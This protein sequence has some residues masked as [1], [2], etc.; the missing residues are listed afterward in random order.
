[1]HESALRSRRQGP[2]ARQAGVI[3]RYAIIPLLA[4]VYATIAFPLI[5]VTCSPTDSACL[6]EARPESKIFWPIL[7]GIALVVSLLGWSRLRFPPILTILFAYLALAGA[8]VAWAF[9]P[10][11]SGVRFL[12]QAMIIVSIMLPAMLAARSTDLLRGLFYC[13]AVAAIL[14]MLFIMGRPPI[15]VKFATWGYPGYFSGKNYLGQCGAVAFLLAFHEMLY[16][17]RRR[18]FGILI[19]LMAIALLFLSNSKTALALA[20]L[21]PV[22]AWFMLKLARLTRIPVSVI[23]VS[24]PL[25]Y[26]VF[27]FV[28]GFSMNRL[29]Y[30]LYGDSTFTGRTIIWDFANS[31]IAKKPL[32][33]WGYQSFWLVG[34]DA[35]SIVN[36]PG[37]VKDMPNAHNGYEDTL[38]ELGY[39][40]LALLLAL[41]VAVLHG[42][43]R[44]AQVQFSRAWILLSVVLYVVVTN[45]L[46][47]TWMRGFE[48]LWIVFVIAAAEVARHWRQTSSATVQRRP[49]AAPRL[50]NA[51]AAR[52][53]PSPAAIGRLR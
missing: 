1:M 27:A 17:G 20:V 24:I 47:S 11:I 50:R 6:Y 38:L 30:M 29:S 7:A 26:A 48:M 19:A 25:A 4:C 46:E 12:Q 14:N 8:S 37:W 3:D 23:L 43:G 45:G 18:A 53:R 35:P 36:A 41:I 16:P 51:S 52:F 33:G 32:L 21:V 9:K 5:L 42:I 15:D 31:E 49:A 2:A 44:L 13:F 40:G 28:T 22:F 34:P 10:E 39:V